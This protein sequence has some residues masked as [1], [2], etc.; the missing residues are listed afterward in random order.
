MLKLSRKVE[1]A[2]MAL[3]HMARLR[4]GELAAARAIS[5][6]HDIPADLLGKVLQNLARA[7]LVASVQGAG[8]GYRLAREFDAITL[9][10]VIEAVEGPVHLAV[11]RDDPAA[12]SQYENCNIKGPV[13]H[14][15]DQ[16]VQYIHAVKLSEFNG[17]AP[18]TSSGQ[19]D[20]AW[21]TA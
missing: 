4:R 10:E 6:Q 8:G 21:P 5:T 7:G 2:L 15:Q 19:A 12:C 16:L 1:Y 17:T 11:C 13:S 3:M 20:A 14:L 18:S 9:G